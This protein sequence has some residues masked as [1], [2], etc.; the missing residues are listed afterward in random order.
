MAGVL[1]IRQLVVLGQKG[2]SDDYESDLIGIMC[3][4]ITKYNYI[5]KETR[6][7]EMRRVLDDSKMLNQNNIKIT[8][9]FCKIAFLL[10][11]LFASCRACISV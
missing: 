3:K 4:I 7:Q 10:P 11:L 9:I 1:V 5:T 8:R 2:S 6:K